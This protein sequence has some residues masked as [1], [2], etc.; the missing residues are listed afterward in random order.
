MTEMNS[1][2]EELS[3]ALRTAMVKGDAEELAD[4]LATDFLWIHA[5]AHVDSKEALL[6]TVRAGAVKHL[7]FE[8][9]DE[10][11]RR[12]G[13][14][15][16]H[17]GIA[18]LHVQVSEDRFRLANRFSIVWALQDDGSWRITNWQSTSMHSN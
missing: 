15:L 3:R 6:D 5:D 2:V 8:A 1:V 13:D 18:S 11:A 17:N 16:V 12:Y 10:T 4:L 14:V 7:E 9:A